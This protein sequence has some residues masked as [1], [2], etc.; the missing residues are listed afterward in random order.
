MT[1][2]FTFVEVNFEGTAG[3]PL[4]DL[5]GINAELIYR[6]DLGPILHIYHV[7]NRTLQAPCDKLHIEKVPRSWDQMPTLMAGKH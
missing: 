4:W 6:T 5:Y 2:T 3:E 7:S 1:F